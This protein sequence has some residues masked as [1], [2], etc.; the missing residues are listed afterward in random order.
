MTSAASIQ[1]RQE[2]TLLAGEDWEEIYIEQVMPHK[3]EIDLDY[4]KRRNMF[5]DVELIF[6]TVLKLISG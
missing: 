4:L 1:Y 2:S 6:K 3:L 5:R